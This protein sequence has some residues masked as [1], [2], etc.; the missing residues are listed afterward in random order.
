MSEQI[1]ETTTALQVNSDPSFSEP[2]NIK[3]L[4]E[5]PL[6]PTQDPFFDPNFF[7]L[8]TNPDFVQLTPGLLRSA[9]GGLRALAGDDFVKGSTDSELI[10]GNIGNDSLLGE[11]GDDTLRGGKGLDVLSG[12]D[13]N[14]ILNG[15]LDQDYIFGNAGD[16]LIRGGQGDDNLV[17]GVGKDTLIG[18][19][20]IDKLWGGLDADVFVL[21]RDKAAPPQDVGSS[22]PR[23]SGNFNVDSIPADIILDYDP[24][25]GDVIG[26]T[27]GLTANDVVV[28][29]I[30]LT[31]GDRRDYNS[32][33]PFPLGVPR[34]ADF[35]LE[36]TSAAIIREAG[37]GN[38]LGL[39]KN[40]SPAQL[41]FVSVTEG[42]TAL[43]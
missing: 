2:A 20:G 28:S 7:N 10:N 14:D 43:G 37:T 16:D 24:A 5:P 21:R 26:L 34:T 11:G 8:T 30:F 35:Q 19:A 38:I 40:V 6:N 17:G 15:N 9:S 22:Q 3:V 1:P 29:E 4:S 39:V 13:G 31:L 27:G 36:N 25:Q 12:G 23:P 18:D 32:S 33:G 42:T 41:R